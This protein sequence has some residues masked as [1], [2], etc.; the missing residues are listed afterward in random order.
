M[1]DYFVTATEFQPL[2]VICCQKENG[3]VRLVSHILCI[4]L[5][6]YVGTTPDLH[7]RRKAATYSTVW[8]YS[9][10]WTVTIYKQ[11]PGEAKKSSSPPL[12]HWY[13]WQQ[14]NTHFMCVGWLSAVYIEHRRRKVRKSLHFCLQETSAIT[15][16]I[17]TMTSLGPP[18]YP[19]NG[20]LWR[21]LYFV[22]H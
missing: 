1:C 21:M 12:E 2:F 13:C 8:A 3:S 5:E 20:C 15:V 19:L 6:G 4:L 17:W 14:P 16:H 18:R 22:I 11:S 7:L 9:G 10:I